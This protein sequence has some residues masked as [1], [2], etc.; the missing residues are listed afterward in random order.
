MLGND[1]GDGLLG[2]SV[3]GAV[4]IAVVNRNEI[5]IV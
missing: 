1:E 3:R 2:Y 5:S 4:G